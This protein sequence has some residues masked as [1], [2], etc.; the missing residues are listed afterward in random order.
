MTHPTLAFV[1]DIGATNFR[2]G[3]AERR[4]DSGEVSLV[5]RPEVVSTPR[6]SD[7]FF[8]AM[9]DAIVPLLYDYPYVRDGV[10]GFPGKV[11]HDGDRMLVGP[12]TNIA[13][14]NEVFDLNERLFEEDKRLGNIRLTALNDAEAATHAA[15]F[16]DGADPANTNPLMYFTQSSGVGGDVIRDHKIASRLTGQLG[17][18]GH[19]PVT[20]DGHT[21]T[22]ENFISGPAIERRYGNHTHSVQQLGQLRTLEAEHAW[23]TVGRTFGRAIAGFVPSIGMSHVVI[24]GGVSRDSHR[25]AESLRTEL[26][27]SLSKNAVHQNGM[28][29]VP[30]VLFVPPE[31][32][33]TIG[34]IGARHGLEQYRD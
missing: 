32:V 24:G 3:M 16:I 12:L 20:I 23:R 29:K 7:E 25:Y 13:G 6:T 10:I 1:G 11:V 9:A 27:V 2:I 17:E 21:D 34:L 5:G 15:P 26:E 4:N 33:S 22:I 19:T 8:R 31:L 14:L 30:E 28:A 18:Y